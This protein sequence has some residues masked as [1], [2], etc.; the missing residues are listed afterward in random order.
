MNDEVRDEAWQIIQKV[1]NS[2]PDSPDLFNNRHLDMFIISAFYMI[3]KNKKLEPKMD[4][5]REVILIFLLFS[6]IIKHFL[7]IFG[8]CSSKL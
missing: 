6:Y 8:G 2:P 5:F 4:K 7:W 3:L 1:F